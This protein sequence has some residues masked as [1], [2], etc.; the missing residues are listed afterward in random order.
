MAAKFLKIL[1]FG[2]LAASLAGCANK[3]AHLL[4]GTETV[5]A[6][7]AEIAG[8]HRLFVATTRQRSAEPREVFDGERS[9]T[10]S[11]A[12]TDVTVPAIHKVGA[13]ERPKN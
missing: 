5:S 10:L 12:V 9:L 1:A 8:K 13:L 3:G 4:V 6:T 11:F 2:V 7:A